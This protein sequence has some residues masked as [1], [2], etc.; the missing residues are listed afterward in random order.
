MSLERGAHTEV[1]G[2]P[3]SRFVVSFMKDVLGD[4]GRRTEICQKIL[5]IDAP[6]E[7]EAKEAGIMLSLTRHLSHAALATF[8][9]PACSMARM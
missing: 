1:V 9:G 8:S 7:D 2:G 4:D 3:M 5:E 6:S